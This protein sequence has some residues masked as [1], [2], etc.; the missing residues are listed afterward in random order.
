MQG[1]V[2]SENAR[3]LAEKLLNISRCENNT[4]NQVWGPSKPGYYVTAQVIRPMELDPQ[5]VTRV[6]RD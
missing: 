2:Q 6:N 1:P 4:L 5:T 3:T